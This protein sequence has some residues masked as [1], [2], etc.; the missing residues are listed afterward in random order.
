MRIFEKSGVFKHSPSITRGK[1]LETLR[2]L[3]VHLDKTVVRKAGSHIPAIVSQVAIYEPEVL[4]IMTLGFE[5]AYLSKLG[6][7]IKIPSS[8]SPKHVS[9][10]L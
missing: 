6:S 10:C 9:G 4:L 8:Q 1:S 7:T 3:E 5:E 2:N